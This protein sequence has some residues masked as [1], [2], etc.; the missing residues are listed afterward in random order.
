MAT[1][2]Q[3]ERARARYLRGIYDPYKKQS[4]ANIAN[5]QRELAKFESESAKEFREAQKR[6]NKLPTRIT[7]KEMVGRGQRLPSSRIT[8][9]SFLR[10]G[11]VRPQDT[12]IFVKGLRA[13]KSRATSGLAQGKALFEKD[14]TSWKKGISEMTPIPWE[15]FKKK[16]YQLAK[17]QMNAERERVYS[18]AAE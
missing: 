1:P 18:M 3:V 10:R 17:Q 11:S 13:N 6:I 4:E 7:R 9:S 15:E 16:Y 12:R 2:G 5:Q 14:R 8:K